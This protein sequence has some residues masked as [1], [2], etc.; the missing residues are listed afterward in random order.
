[1]TWGLIR[2]R[3]ERHR[4]EVSAQQAR[5]VVDQFY[6]RFHEDRLLGQ[7]SLRP[8]RQALLR[9][10]RRFYETFL[11]EHRGD[12]TLRP[13]L[14]A[15]GSRV[16]RISAEVDPPVQALAESK[17]AVASWESLA[18]ALLGEPAYRRGL[19]DALNDLGALL[20][21]E[22]QRDEALVTLRRAQDLFETLIAEDPRSAATRR[23]LGRALLNIASIQFAERRMDEAVKS[24]E[25]VL[26]IETQR[27]DEDTSAPDPKLSLARAQNLLAQIF[28][29]QPGGTAP[30]IESSQ[31]AVELLESISKERPELA[32]P[33]YLRALY[34][35]DLNLVQ[36]MA[37][38][39][40]SALK[41]LRQAVEIL[42]RLDQ[43][44]PGVLEYRGSLAATENMLSELHRLRREPA[45]SLVIAQKARGRLEGLVAEQPEDIASRV[46][47]A[48]AHNNV[49]TVLQQSGDPVAALRAFQRAVDSYES[50]AE[51]D[52]RNSYGLARNI[53]LGLRLIGAQPGS[54]GVSDPETLSKSDR[55]RRQKY[56]DRAVELLR[57]AIKGGFANLEMLESDPDLDPLRER[58]DFRELIKTLEK[59]STTEPR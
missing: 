5:E 48:R 57:R 46:D 28:A 2:A 54:K 56:G 23:E 3:R 41:S 13:E 7:P 45:E 24:L 29:E 1:M 50:L 33:R 39:L 43:Q 51:L 52:P 21:H 26:A 20:L 40:D 42:E 35:G 32:E 49:G 9:D 27:A 31:K 10:A 34:L 18:S 22:R 47:L 14:A 19:A 59:E 58:P 25:R 53:A 6:T 37:G 12:L 8:L 16:A 17:Q 15:A 38:K 4:A 36:Q 11:D 30:S 55:F 44:Y